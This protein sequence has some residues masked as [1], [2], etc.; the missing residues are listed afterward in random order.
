MINLSE[1]NKNGSDSHVL[2]FDSQRVQALTLLFDQPLFFDQPVF[3][4]DY[5]TDRSV[6]SD[7]RARQDIISDNLLGRDEEPEDMVM[8]G[9]PILRRMLERA[10]HGVPSEDWAAELDEM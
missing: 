6:S 4:D 5:R 10:M 1:L 2:K 8:F 9:S 3:F 7:E